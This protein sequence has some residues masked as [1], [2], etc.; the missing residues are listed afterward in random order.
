MFFLLLFQIS[1][2][3]RLPRN[4]YSC[5]GNLIS[6]LYVLV[7]NCMCIILPSS[8]YS[9]YCGFILRLQTSMCDDSSKFLF[10]DLC[11][12][13]YIT[14]YVKFRATQHF[15]KENH[16]LD[17]YV[18]CI[19]ILLLCPIMVF[20]LYP[21]LQ[22]MNIEYFSINVSFNFS[23]VFFFIFSFSMFFPW[24]SFRLFY[25]FQGYDT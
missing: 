24:V 8:Q 25:L 13:R 23:Q 5:A 15:K 20:S 4:I 17:F 21:L 10:Q 16:H 7:L 1:F 9:D 18:N 14:S 2:L 22:F 12:E 19:G 6:R 11:I 3:I